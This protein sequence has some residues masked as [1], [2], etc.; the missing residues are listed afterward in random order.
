MTVACIIGTDTSIGKTYSCCQIMKYIIQW[1]YTIA[2]LKPIASGIKNYNGQSLNEDV[3]QLAKVSNYY[4]NFKQINPFCL[5]NA[6]APHI[7]AEYEKQNLRV[8]DVTQFINKIISQTKTANHILIEGV[9]GLMVPLNNEEL[10]LDLLI[11]WNYPIILVVGIKLGCLNHALL[12]NMVLKQHNLP[13][14]GWI[15]NQIDPQMS[16]LQEN[17]NYLINKLDAPMIANINFQG[18]LNPTQSFKDLFQCP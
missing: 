13:L 9:G 16:F 14:V 2:T 15:A 8:D 6:V 5:K 10:Y 1:N 11:K 4:L 18:N 7:A 17:L 3:Y 12:T